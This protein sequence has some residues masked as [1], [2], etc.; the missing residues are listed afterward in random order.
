MTMEHKGFKDECILT[1]SA[2]ESA[3]QMCNEFFLKTVEEWVAEQR[4][5]VQK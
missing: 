1:Q 3:K 5:T 4:S 2:R